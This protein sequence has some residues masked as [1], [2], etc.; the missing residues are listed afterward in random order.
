MMTDDK[1]VSLK[2]SLDAKLQAQA[3]QR[4]ELSA[5]VDRLFEAHTILA[6]AVDAMRDAALS[7]D[8]IAR[9]LRR[10]A[11]LLSERG[12]EIAE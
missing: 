9:L 2:A 7:D 5:L 3:R 8:E 4:Q 11:D 10:A 6:D 12:P 1:I